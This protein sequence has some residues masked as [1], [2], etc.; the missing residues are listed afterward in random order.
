MRTDE[1]DWTGPD[2]DVIVVGAGFAGATAARECATRGLR[3]LVLEARDRIGGRTH[4]A[5]LSD[6]EVVELGGTWVHWMQPHVW[7]E[8]TRYGLEGDIVAGAEDPAWVLAP[9][10]GGLTWSS[11]TQHAARERRLGELF[12]GPSRA[13]L[14]R[15]W[16]PLYAGDAVGELDRLSLR[17]RLDQI[18]VSEDDA[19]LLLAWVGQWTASTDVE[20]SFL[21]A[22]RFWAA[23]GHDYDVSWETLIGFKLKGGT[24][25]LLSAMLADGDAEVRLGSPVERID[26]RPDGVAV[27]C[28]DGETHTAATAIVATPSGVWPD[29]EF[30]PPLPAEQLAAARAGMQAPAA[31]KVIAVIRGESRSL[32]VAARP[33]QPLG[34]MLTLHRRSEDEQVVVIFPGAAMR[35]AA[36][37]DEVRAAITDVLPH[38]EV[39]ESLSATYYRDDEFARGGWGFLRPGQL[40]RFAPHA[41]FTRH[42]HRVTFA[43]AD[44]ARLWPSFIDGAIESGLRAGRAVRAS[45]THARDRR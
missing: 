38:V 34:L 20:G 2:H 43:T 32:F 5:R 18:E 26:S 15:P 6:G 39:T 25:G 14:P 36:D 33:D 40:T 11:A 19:D 37:R 1:A 41:R 8:I 23:A 13:G 45:V 27:R 12:F 3:T 24:V 35:D 21:S 42:G 29:F 7:S 44:L 31:A 9:G 16:D 30:S 17:D 28:R 10:P 22:M 4:T